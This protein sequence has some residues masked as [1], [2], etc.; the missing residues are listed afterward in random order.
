MIPQNIEQSF[1]QIKRITKI[2][3]I[4]LLITFANIKR[5]HSIPHVNKTIPTSKKLT[6]FQNSILLA[7]PGGL[8]S[9]ARPQ[10]VVLSGGW[11]NQNRGLR[12]GIVDSDGTICW[13][14]FTVDS[15]GLVVVTSAGDAGLLELE[16]WTVVG[17]WRLVLVW[18]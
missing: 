4:Q 18:C 17:W 2:T 13:F 1:Q 7:S 14:D 5:I 10:I 16:F 3:I 12:L 9:L 6:N 11:C 15:C 8:G